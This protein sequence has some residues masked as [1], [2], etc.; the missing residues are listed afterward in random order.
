MLKQELAQRRI[1]PRQRFPMPVR[2]MDDLLPG[3][4]AIVEQRRAQ[5]SIL[6]IPPGAYP[7]RRAVWGLE[8]PFG[9]RRTPERFLL[10][11]QDAITVIEI[12]PSGNPITTDIPLMSLFKVH[13]VAI[14]L[15]AYL[16]L[17]WV[18]GSHVEV[19]QIEYNS[20][21]QH[22]IEREIDRVRALHPPCFSP[23]TIPAQNRETILAPLPFKFR[24][25]MRSS[26][27]NDEHLLAAVFQPAI[28]RGPGRLRP[29]LTPNRAIGVT[30][31]CLIVIEDRQH[32]RFSE[33]DYAILRYFYP[34]S[35]IQNI[36]F[37]TLPDV[38]WLRL[39]HSAMG[40]SQQTD[41]PL[42]PDPLNALRGVLSI[43]RA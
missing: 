4:R 3:V 24:N 35:H 34:L 33:A 19:K 37:E 41:I 29:Y 9:W 18:E 5:P 2:G 17:V 23:D 10:F 40:V 1:D 20:V 36:A 28:R 8:L 22:L 16:E 26:L 15:Y 6:R 32:Q 42:L 43:S 25:Y 39:Q 30:E 12:D 13:H 31:R 7:I 38:S 14:L 11:D 27:L 21:G